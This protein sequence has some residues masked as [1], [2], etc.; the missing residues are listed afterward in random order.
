[1]KQLSYILISLSLLFWS[2]QILS[3]QNK[4]QIN[5]YFLKYDLSPF[6][7]ATYYLD[8]E[9]NENVQSIEYVINDTINVQLN[10]R[11]NKIT[12]LESD[13]TRLNLQYRFGRVVKMQTLIND[14]NTKQ[15]KLIHIFPFVFFYDNGIHNIACKWL[16]KITKVKSLSGCTTMFKTKMRYRWGKIYKVKHYGWRTVAQKCHYDGYTTY[17][18]EKDNVVI[19]N[20]YDSNDSLAFHTKYFFDNQGNILRIE[21]LTR[22]RVSGWGIDA[23]FYAY[24]SNQVDICQYNYIFDEKNNWI[25]KKESVNDTLINHTVRKINY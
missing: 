7:A 14:K 25:V 12:S 9:L 1:M 4:K 19:A 15:T 17:K 20:H 16:G 2:S 10:L 24:D 18:Y 3:A 5:H 21:S 11:K 22:K 6:D 13:S 8:S 23:T